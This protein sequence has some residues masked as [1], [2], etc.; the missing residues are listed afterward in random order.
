MTNARK[1]ESRVPTGFTVIELLVVIGVISV[2]AGLLLPAVQSAREAA[3]LTQCKN[4]VKQLALGCLTFEES[5]GHFPGNGWGHRW[6]GDPDRGF[7][8]QQP[9]G[10]IFQ[11][12]PFTDQQAV[13]EFGGMT[14]SSVEKRDQLTARNGLTLPLLTCPTRPGP[15]TVDPRDT[16]SLFNSYRAEQVQRTD[17]A[18][19]EGS[20]VSKT[21]EGPITLAVG[22]T[23]FPWRNISLIVDGI[24]FQRSTVRV[25]DVVK[26]LSNTL[27][28][29][30]KY[31]SE[32]SYEESASLSH[33]QSALSG[34]EWDIARWT[35]APPVQD[36]PSEQ[37][38]RF[39][40]A[41]ATSIVA[42]FCDG[43][44]RCVSFNIDAV[45]FERLG[46]VRY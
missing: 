16:P 24:S 5:Q 22:D 36:S 11:T 2:L 31:V 19:S 6:T 1:P 41:H 8:P 27:L 3:R 12:L 32:I 38:R 9:G 23:S 28:I 10:W 45:L 25:D 21:G 42:S 46:A 14:S 20:V 34:V 18:V 40:S 35:F 17:Y 33:D 44:V 13:Y 4:N 43:S 7:G 39:G 30:E 26:G 15:Q 37:P 29:G